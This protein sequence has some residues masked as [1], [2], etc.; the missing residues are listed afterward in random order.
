VR[1]GFAVFVL[2][3]VCGEALA[4]TPAES[5][6]TIKTVGNEGAGHAAAVRAMKELS[7]ADAAALPEILRAFDD[8]SSLQANWLRG[9]FE[10]VADRART[11][12]KLSATSLEGFVKDTARNPAARRMAFEWLL[13]LDASASERLIPGMLQDPSPEFRRDAVARLMDAAVK[14]TDSNKDAAVTAYRQALSGAVDDDQVKAIVKPLREL[15]ETVDLQQHFGF[16]PA[17][18]LIGP[19][20]N[21]GGKG[22][23]TV[24]PPERELNFSAKYAGK[25]EEVAWEEHRTENEYGI[26]DLAKALEPFKGAVT[27]AATEYDSAS[28]QVVDVRLGTPNAW[29][30]WVNGQL[31]FGRDEYHRN[32][33]IDQ[34]RVR[35]PLKK[36]RNVLL[37]KVCQNEQPEDWAQRWQ[38][39][40][41]ICDAAGAAILPTT[42]KTSSKNQNPNSKLE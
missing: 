41:R 3:L 34:Y 23:D 30:L 14:L 28:D 38:Y 32:M 39:Q 19:F 12:K 25:T 7:H 17:W 26:V 33:Q 8:A 31:L 16:L 27:Y 11:E 10:A 36:G 37:L 42:I 9:A 35:A 29:K 13:K 21:A 22:F 40:I 6:K 18:R 24:Y 4:A 20:D 15:G 1:C 2:G 5:I